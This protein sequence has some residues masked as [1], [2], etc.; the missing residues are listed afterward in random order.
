MLQH[1]AAHCYTLPRTATSIRIILIVDS[2]NK[3]KPPDITI[4]AQ[5]N[6][7]KMRTYLNPQI[8][9]CDVLEFWNKPPWQFTRF[10]RYIY[11]WYM[12]TFTNICVC[13]CNIYPFMYIY[14][15]VYLYICIFTCKYIYKN[16]YINICVLINIFIWYIYIYIYMYVYVYKYIYIHV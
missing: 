6:H 7:T 16:T 11:V 4:K 2:Q 5:T 15:H 10:Q 14:I 12:N 3:P 13:I 9:M 1:T 8:S